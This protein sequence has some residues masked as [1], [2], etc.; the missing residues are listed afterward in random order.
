M[1]KI[2]RIF[3][4]LIYI[5]PRSASCPSNSYQEIFGSEALRG[6]RIHWKINWILYAI[7]FCFCMIV[8]CVHGN[9]AGRMGLI[10][11]IFNLIYNTVLTY[12][13]IYRKSFRFAGYAKRN[14]E[15]G[16]HFAS[17]ESVR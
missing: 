9:E 13:I 14:Q 8:Y 17:S 16:I 6:E 12:S 4:T 7:L 1:G 15:S 11:A 2:R 3:K 10:L 5:S